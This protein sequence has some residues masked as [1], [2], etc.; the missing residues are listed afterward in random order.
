MR[1][2]LIIFL[3]IACSVAGA[4]GGIPSI[5]LAQ[6]VTADFSQWGRNEQLI[7][8]ATGAY[9]GGEAKAQPPFTAEN[10]QLQ[11]V[12]AR[13][14]LGLKASTGGIQFSPS[15]ATLPTNWQGFAQLE[16]DLENKTDDT[17]QVIWGYRGRWIRAVDTIPFLPGQRK[18]IA[19]PLA[20]LPI[21]AAKETPY[22]PGA[23]IWEVRAKK[24]GA[25]MVM[26]QLALLTSRS[27]KSQPV[28]DRFGQRRLKQ[29]QGKV[30][31][32]K[33]L[34]KEPDIPAVATWARQPEYDRYGG[35]TFIQQKATGFFYILQQQDRWWWVTPEGHPFWS[36]GVTGIR[37][38]ND[39]TDVTWVK[40]REQLYE[41]LPDRNGPFASA[42]VDSARMSFYYVNLLRKYGHIQTWREQVMQ[43]LRTWGLNSMGNWSED[44]LLLQSDLPFTKSFDSKIPGYLVGRGLCD[45]FHPG[46]IKGVDSM[47]AG[48]VLFRNNPHLL[49]YFVDNEQ[50]WGHGDFAGILDILPDTAVSRREWLKVLKQ[51]YPDPQAVGVACGRVISSWDEA[52]GINSSADYE[53]LKNAVVDFETRFA[54][55]YFS[56][57]KA[58]LKKYDPNHL[59]LGCR[60]T[61]Q[62]KPWHVMQTA[63]QY[64]DVVTVN[65]YTFVEDEMKKWHAATGRPIL[66]GE[67]H[68]PLA[69][70][71]QFPPNYK[72]FPEAERQTYYLNY[73]QRWAKLPFSL[74][75]HW[76]QFADQ[77]LTGRSTDGE[78]QTV[79]LVDITDTPHRH[80]IEVMQRASGMMYQ[81]HLQSK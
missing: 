6:T 24:T 37:P 36:L 16:A 53:R 22:H 47:A 14:E 79:G 9:G 77:H 57:V 18:K 3:A 63:G 23:I 76:Y 45:V 41:W 32:E 34:Q 62:L 58:A 59:Y 66:I 42:W 11:V 68:A 69:S 46:W 44:S 20:E 55:Q 15:F 5:G 60:F 17:L 27:Q 73:V 70:S 28:V 64:C 61:R 13:L 2:K 48:A 74:G 25:I 78:C 43:R 50:G 26:H 72:A 10:A 49:G 56:T 4:V 8:N 19:Y 12:L 7:G 81:W 39:R 71:R 51:Y 67:H 30:Q 38:K 29:W 75:C 65:V 1:Q 52:M 35:H 31:Q 21:A 80:M 54:R 40:G 33:D